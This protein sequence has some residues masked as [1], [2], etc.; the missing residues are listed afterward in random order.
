MVTNERV[1][2]EV[3]AEI[4]RISVW[5]NCYTGPGYIAISEM[6]IEAI[7]S[8]ANHQVRNRLT[9]EMLDSELLA[10]AEG[11]IGWLE[12]TGMLALVEPS[13]LK[14]L[15]AAIAAEEAKRG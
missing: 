7:R 6:P 2:A 13:R 15:R 11:V 9:V 1:Q 5:R 14:A 12:Y 3:A 8:L 10:A 4:G